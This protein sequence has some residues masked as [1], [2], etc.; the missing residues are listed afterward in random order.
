MNVGFEFEF[1]LDADTG[2]DD[3]DDGT[4]MVGF[5]NGGVALLVVLVVDGDGAVGPAV[6]TNWV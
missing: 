2:S 5:R 3:D 1:E 6:T 4:W